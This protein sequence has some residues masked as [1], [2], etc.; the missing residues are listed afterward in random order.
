MDKELVDKM[1]TIIQSHS[2]SKNFQV[3]TFRYNDTKYEF[4]VCKLFGEKWLKQFEKSS[5]KVFYY[6]FE[7]NYTRFCSEKELQVYVTNSKQNN[8]GSDCINEVN[9]KPNED[10]QN[11]KLQQNPSDNSLQHLNKST[12]SAQKSDFSRNSGDGGDINEENSESNED[13]HNTGLQQPPS[14][15]FLENP[16]KST[17]SDGKSDSSSISSGSSDCDTIRKRRQK[18][19]LFK[20]KESSGLLDPFSTSMKKLL[21]NSTKST[22]RRNVGTKSTV[23]NRTYETRNRKSVY[24]SS[25]SDSDHEENFVPKK[26]EL[27]KRSTTSSEGST[28][29]QCRQ[30]N[31]IVKTWCTKCN[32]GKGRI[33]EP[34]LQNRYGETI[35]DSKQPDWSCPA[36]RGVCNCSICMRKKGEQP[37]GQMSPQRRF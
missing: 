36:C 12:V 35:S 4:T 7:T 15:N 13:L 29:H 25:D 16:N 14:D 2:K 33:C 6:N 20:Q 30:K 22:H 19:N 23:P 21:P 27:T 10:L 5:Q 24:K 28:C 34:C 8:V 17:I 1:F 3:L 9:S 26:R 32:S 18:S 11:T 31:K 37:T